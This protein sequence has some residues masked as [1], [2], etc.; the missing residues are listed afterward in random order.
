M[1]ITTFNPIIVSP[2]SGDVIR[3]FEEFGFEKTHAPVT[4]LENGE[5]QDIRMKNESGFHIDIAEDRN[6]IPNDLVLIRMNVDDFEEAYNIFI[7]HGF[8]NTRGDDT[9]NTKTSKAATMV[10][11]S[12]ITIVLVKHIKK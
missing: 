5:V 8:K 7:K 11:P 6:N 4:E 2:K 1:K 3:L 9:L 12:G 10:S